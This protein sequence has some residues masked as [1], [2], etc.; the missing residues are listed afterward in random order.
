MAP[1]QSKRFKAKAPMCSRCSRVFGLRF[2][3]RAAVT[4]PRLRSIPI[5]SADMARPLYGRTK[6]IPMRDSSSEVEL[7]T[8]GERRGFRISCESSRRGHRLRLLEHPTIDRLGDPAA[9]ISPR[10]ASPL[11]ERV[12]R[13]KV[14]KI[15]R[16]DG[17]RH[18]LEKQNKVCG[19]GVEFTFEQHAYAMYHG[20]SSARFSAGARGRGARCAGTGPSAGVCTLARTLA[21]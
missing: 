20:V 8:T 9:K 10:A 17:G 15:C 6:P 3:A 1:I 11:D 14:A 7:T 5:M 19:V 13:L 18:F 21:S 16:G 12:G 2:E 4:R